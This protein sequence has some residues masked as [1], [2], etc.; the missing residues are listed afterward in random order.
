MGMQGYSVSPLL[1]KSMSLRRASGVVR[2]TGGVV[3]RRVSITL[4]VTGMGCLVHQ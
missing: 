1:L 2:L 3:S 4:G